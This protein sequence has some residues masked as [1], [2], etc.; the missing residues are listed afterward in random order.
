VPSPVRIASDTLERWSVNLLVA[1]GVPAADAQEVARHLVFADLR[2][3]D[4]HGTSRLKLYISRL[5]SGAMSAKT[6]SIVRNETPISALVD[7]ANGLGQVV[8]RRATDMT[9]AKA[10][11]RG[12]ATVAVTASNHCGCMGYYTLLMA[13]RGLIGLATTNATA[14]MPPHGGREPFFGTNPISFAA[15]T[16]SAEPFVFDMATSQVARGKIMSAARKGLPIPEGWAVDRQGH[17]TTDAADALQGMVLPVGG[18][19]GSALAAMIEILSGILSGGPIGP[20]IPRI[21]EDL[22][23]PQGIGHFFLAIRPDLFMAEDQF[24]GRM[25]RMLQQLR[26]TPPAEGQT[27]V[28]AP[29]DLEYQRSKEQGQI[30]VTIAAQV[31]RDFEELAERYEVSLPLEFVVG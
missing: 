11:A 13:D 10:L 29:G 23:K 24:R 31:Y 20:Q 18:P 8:A 9:I 5:E 14:N 27:R 21:Y 3:I 2:G 25:D 22:F 17:P 16:G 19:K 4:T 7:G 30:G 28:F 26:S 12:I 15:P 6:N 1:A